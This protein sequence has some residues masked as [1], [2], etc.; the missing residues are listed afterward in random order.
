MSGTI[1][2]RPDPSPAPL[3]PSALASERTLVA[4]C[5][6]PRTA[7]LLMVCTFLDSPLF[8]PRLRSLN[9]ASFLGLRKWH[10]PCFRTGARPEKGNII[11]HAHRRGVSETRSI[12]HERCRLA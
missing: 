2:G 6:H 12:R 1:R 9:M 7:L 10:V 11:D 5:P 8:P 3:S 4:L